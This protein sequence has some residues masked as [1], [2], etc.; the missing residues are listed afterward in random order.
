VKSIEAPAGVY[1][2]FGSNIDP[3]SSITDALD[4]IAEHCP[5]ESLSTLYRSAPWERGEQDDFVNGICRIQSEWGAHALKFDI[6]RKIEAELGRNR[7]KDKH[8]PRCIDLDV[9][10]HGDLVT[11]EA[12]LRLPDPDIRTRPFLAVPLLELAPD[13]VF[14]DSGEPLAKMAIAGETDGLHPMIE[15]TERLKAR[16]GL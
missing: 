12:G 1:I 4:Q 8:A 16:H 9:I 11:K 6:L 13:Y 14:P 2:G 7:T 15:L 3:E 5:L 10:I